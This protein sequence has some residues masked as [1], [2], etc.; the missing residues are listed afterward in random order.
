MG[1]TP[2]AILFFT[3]ALTST[4][5]ADHIR[6]GF[7]FT[8]G[9]TQ[10]RAISIGADDNATTPNTHRSATDLYCIR[11]TT[12]GTISFQAKLK[13]F[14]SDGFT[15]TNDNNTSA[16]TFP[17][18]YAALGGAD[19]TNVKV[20]S[21]TP[22]TT[23]GNQDI[24]DVGFEPD[25]VF[26]MGANTPVPTSAAGDTT[27]ASVAHCTWFWG[28]AKSS[29]E[30]HV[31][32]G[33]SV[34]TGASALSAVGRYQRTTKCISILAATADP[35]TVA[36]EADYVGTISTGTGG[37]RINWSTAP[38]ST[39]AQPIFYLAIKG[40]TYGIGTV[41]AP[42]TTSG[43]QSITGLGHTPKGLLTFSNMAI[44]A[45]GLSTSVHRFMFGGANSSTSQFDVVGLETGALNPT[46]SIRSH[47]TSS[48]IWSVQDAEPSSAST[49]TSQ[50]SLTSFDSDSGGGYTLNWT[51]I[52]TGNA[53]Q[54][55]FV[56]VGDSPSV[57]TLYKSASSTETI[58]ETSKRLITRYRNKKEPNIAIT[59]TARRM[60]AKRSTSSPVISTVFDFVPD[61]FKEGDF[62]ISRTTLVSG[63]EQIT[64][65]T[66]TIATITQEFITA[67]NLVFYFS[68]G[69]TIN[70]TTNYLSRGGARS[71][72]IVP[73]GVLGGAWD[74]VAIGEATAG[75]VEF[76][77]FYLYNN[78]T[79][80][81][82]YGLKLYIK[83][84]LQRGQIQI[85]LGTSAVN[86]TETGPLTAEETDPNLSFTTAPDIDSALDLPDLT[87]SSSIAIWEKRI[88]DPNTKAFGNDN[89]VL[90]LSV[91]SDHV[92][93]MAGVGGFTTTGFT[94][95]GF[96]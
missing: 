49:T 83:R 33:A 14:D 15:L 9:A 11:Q 29:T 52:D 17:I 56:T 37:F 19:I 6:H 90:A 28:T 65:H 44:S 77:C 92:G 91:I 55:L 30:R 70:T 63:G 80:L 21:F 60:I 76:R 95:S 27:P 22:N 69:T 82:A 32:A 26:F 34:E 89:C 7:G 79:S 48:V 93:T 94:S 59:E 40:G 74:N 73:N 10:N 8:A 24:N 42:I 47:T 4:T 87:P 75:E 45:S 50:A 85:A 58:T 38:T 36:A 20:G 66:Y 43:P 3:P 39:D 71:N 18:Y 2:K 72:N 25:L 57:G 31:M 81:T 62:V 54:F 1:F 53:R 88:M 16:T 5:P 84:Q 35:V 67:Q 86:G 68:G 12:S 51:T 13:T 78:H 41:T 64:E 61:D 23:T 96:I 46:R